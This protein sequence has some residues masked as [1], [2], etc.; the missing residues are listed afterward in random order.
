MSVNRLEA[1]MCMGAVRTTAARGP[2]G[3]RRWGCDEDGTNRVLLLEQVKA[4]I[5]ILKGLGNLHEH[6]S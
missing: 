1:G 4:C 6:R 5:I 3:F 2:L